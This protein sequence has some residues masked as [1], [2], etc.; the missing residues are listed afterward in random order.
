MRHSGELI[1]Q[2]MINIL[3]ICGKLSI[4]GAEKVVYEIGM[5]CDPSRFHIDYLVFFDEIGEL[6]A[7]LKKHGH[8]VIRMPL[9]SAGYGAFIGGLRKLMRQGSY[10]VVHSHTM[11]N[12]GLILTVAR[13]MGVPVRISHAHTISS[14]KR[15]LARRLYERFMRQ[16]IVSNATDL[17][18]CGRAA[19]IWLY[20]EKAFRRKGKLILNGVDVRKYRFDSVKRR[21]IRDRYGLDASFVIGH[22]GRMAPEK[23]QIFLVE[24]MPEIL[25]R[26]PDAVLLLVGDGDQRVL[27]EDR[28]RKLGIAEAV[29][30][31]G[32]VLN[33]QDYL[34][35]MDVFVLPSV[36]EGMPLSVV[37]TQSNGLPCLLSSAVP[38]D[39]HLTDLVRT[40][41]LQ[42]PAEK[43]IS[44]ILD[45][46]RK[47]PESYNERMLKSGFDIQD[48]VGKIYE[49]YSRAE[50]KEKT[51]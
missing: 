29:I 19:G 1:E 13:Q 48:M 17:V 37:E 3:M 14:M 10:Q 30:L 4:G 22:A 45:S 40:V 5:H 38:R 27:L 36:F 26:R 2:D 28:I 6:E 46:E 33:V 20:G 12:S 8:N 42:D 39:V 11:F 49:I 9:P 15:T 31:T 41:S 32:M 25:R 7:P 44:G 51:G 43:W 24:L 16:L 35:A 21:E 34:S 18:A 23:N 47:D 50:E